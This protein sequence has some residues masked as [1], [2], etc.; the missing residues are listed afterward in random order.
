MTRSVLLRHGPPGCEPDPKKN[1]ACLICVSFRMMFSQTLNAE[2][3]HMPARSTDSP[4]DSVATALRFYGPRGLTARDSDRSLS[5]QYALP[6][7]C[8]R[9][10]GSFRRYVSALPYRHTA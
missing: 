3:Q 9:S 8:F 1:S 5:P 6:G 7:Q 4:T 10:S 2:S